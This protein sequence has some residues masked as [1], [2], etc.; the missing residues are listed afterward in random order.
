MTLDTPLAIALRLSSNYLPLQDWND[1][2][3]AGAIPNLRMVDVEK[4]RA[5]VKE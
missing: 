3:A 1:L 2:E 4:A 5:W